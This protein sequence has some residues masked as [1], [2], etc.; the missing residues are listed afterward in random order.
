M[1]FEN[2]RKLNGYWKLWNDDG[3]I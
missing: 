2:V 3:S 1:K